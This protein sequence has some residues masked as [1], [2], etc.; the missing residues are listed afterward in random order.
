VTRT[1][2]EVIFLDTRIQRVLHKYAKDIGEDP[3]WLDRVF[4]FTRGYRN[5][6]IQHVPR[7][8]TH[9]HVR[10]Y[11]PVAQEL[12]RRAH[13]LL[14]ELDI[15]K[16]PVHTVKHVAR[17]GQTLGQIAARY[18]TSVRAIMQANGLKTTQIRAG[19]A[20]RIPV[21]SAAPPSEPLVVPARLL[22]PS[23]PAAIAGI[24]WPTAE[25]PASTI[26]QR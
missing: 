8:R 1:D 4:Q 7:H 6:L 20:Y 11:N 25:A 24:E 10:F 18:G 21:R 17:S 23:T 9:Y 13:P 14:V 5:A 22:P 15:M 12:G 2:V 16:P 3:A 26:S 19:R